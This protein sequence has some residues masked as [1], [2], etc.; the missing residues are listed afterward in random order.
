MQ[1]APCKLIRRHN[2]SHVSHFLVSSEILS[3]SIASVFC[4]SGKNQG[5]RPST[6]ISFNL[7]PYSK[8]SQVTWSLS[9]AVF[10]IPES[11]G[12]DTLA[13]WPVW[14]LLSSLENYIP[15]T[16][17]LLYGITARSRVCSRSPSIPLRPLP[18]TFCL[19]LWFLHIFYILTFHCYE[20]CYRWTSVHKTC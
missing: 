3:A 1:N 19:S 7:W 12:G 5:A 16:A 18:S 2:F 15:D 10:I 17:K 8:R 11:L 4:L 9:R 13:A 6:W 20:I 14:A